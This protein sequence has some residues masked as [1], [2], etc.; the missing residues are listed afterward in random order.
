MK[1]VQS[2]N[3]YQEALKYIAGGV[4]SPVRSL[5]SVGETPLF[6]KKATGVKLTDIDNNQFTDFCLSWGV[7]ILGHNHPLVNKAVKAAVSKGTSYGI[8]SLQETELAKQVN[9]YIP[10]MERIRFVNSGTEA[11]MS[12][13]RL[14]RGFTR[15]NLLIKFDGCYHGHADHLLVS[16]GSGVADL[17]SASSLGVPDS[18][19]SHTISIPFNNK[20]EVTKIFRERGKEIAAVIVEPVPANMG[21]IKPKSNFLDFLRDMTVK[22]EALLIFDEVIT[23][24]R[25][26]IG[27]AQRLFGI[28][29][30]ITTIG[31]IIGGG[32]PAAAF[33][34]REDIMSLL[35]PQGPVYQAGTL[36]GNP[37]AMSAGL[38]T[39]KLLSAEDFYS[40]LNHKANMF[41]DELRDSVSGKDITINHLGSMFTLFFTAN[42]VNS[43]ED[44]RRISL[45]RFAKFFRYMLSHRFYIS[46][47]Q[48]ETN[49]ISEKHDKRD[50]ARFVEKVRKFKD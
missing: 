35:A 23:G 16:A 46:P 33:G 44:V 25:L 26:S 6:I 37:V 2:V 19:T 45:H 18:F 17:R 24:F 7:F 47:S 27:G 10:S 30:D 9:Q 31:K 28:I 39:L 41:I 20:E 40:R 36:S 3:A 4:N 13:I 43:F 34:G 11:V 14:A 48:F 42:E 32:F 21:L 5:Q 1:R 12:A 50:L 49:F 15:R 29:P 8:P 38:Q 22:H